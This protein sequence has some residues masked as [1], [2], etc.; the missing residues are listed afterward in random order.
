MLKVL[1]IVRWAILTE[2]EWHPVAKQTKLKV[3][4][5]LNSNH[6]TNNTAIK[7]RVHARKELIRLFDPLLHSREQN[8]N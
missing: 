5:H 3:I 1:M 8:I 2:E 4:I 6:V 7:K